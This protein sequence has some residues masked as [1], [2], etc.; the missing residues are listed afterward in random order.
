M[1]PSKLLLLAALSAY[2]VAVNAAAAPLANPP[3]G[4]VYAG[5]YTDSASDR[6][7]RNKGPSEA[8]PD[9]DMTIENCINACSSGLYDYTYVGLQYFHE[10]SLQ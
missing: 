2:T 1:A 6:T 4:F 3:A 10:V 7:L 5:C 8:G 9:A